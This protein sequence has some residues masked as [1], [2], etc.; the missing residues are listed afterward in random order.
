MNNGLKQ[1]TILS[2][3]GLVVA[4]MIGVGV[5]VSTGYMA[6]D[7]SA[8]PI[9][10]A[11]LVG[12]VVAICG[13]VAYSGIVAAIRESGGEYRFLSDLV[14]P[15]LGYVAGWGSLVLGFSAAIAVD[16]HAIGSFLNT[17]LPGP[18]PRMA[19]AIVVVAMTILHAFD[20]KLSHKGQNLLVSFKLAFLLLFVLLALTMGNN[21]MPTWSP[22]NKTEGF[23]WIKVI[24]N[25]FWIA[26]AFSGWN[27]AIYAAGEFRNPGRDVPRS[28]MIGLVVVG[29]LYL[30]INWVFVANLTPADAVAVF[31]YEETRITLAHLIANDI[32]GRHGGLIVSILV[33]IAFL[34]AI[35]AMMVIGPRVYAAMADDGY[36]PKI[37]KPC[38][39]KPPLNATLLQAT[40]SL[41]LLFSH[42]LREAVLAASAF[43][44]LFTALTA[45]SLFRLRR[46]NRQPYPSRYQ[47]IASAIFILAVTVI[48]VTGLQTATV[49]WYS[50]GVVLLLA[51]ITYLVTLYVRRSRGSE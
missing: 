30:V 40:V 25:Q 36:L 51:T 43:L 10:V 42:T 50:F 41:L 21:A 3:A 26:F 29:I 1:H 17:L 46:Y 39:G 48:L 5:L 8:K 12:T 24:E 13:V 38:S 16:A 18:D 7:M 19:G 35:S 15:F 28:M 6:Q 33:I 27:A 47:L 11:W 45:A 49:Q 4:D 37:F 44:L 20:T 14:H 9:L 23:P 32:F 31:T 34:S 22:P 2:G